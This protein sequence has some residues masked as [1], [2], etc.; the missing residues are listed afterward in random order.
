M[1]KIWKTDIKGFLCDFFSPF[2]CS[3]SFLYLSWT[4]ILHL[5]LYKDIH[6]LLNNYP[7]L[8]I[9]LYEFMFINFSF[10]SCTWP[11][12]SFAKLSNFLIF[13]KEIALM[14]KIMVYYVFNVVGWWP[15]NVALM[16][17]TFLSL[18]SF[19]KNTMQFEIQNKS[20]LFIQF[21]NITISAYGTVRWDVFATV[22]LSCIQ[23]I[24]IKYYCIKAFVFYFKE[25]THNYLYCIYFK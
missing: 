2:L 7:Y 21:L 9:V 1:Y 22:Y 15:F 17:W 23:I 5:S 3:S 8:S 14:S 4:Q 25:T 20:S 13:G 6:V 19:Q 16:F 10:L 24:G 18:K 11:V 12:N